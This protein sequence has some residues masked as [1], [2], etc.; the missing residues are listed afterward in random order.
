[1]TINKAS[2]AWV[3][4]GLIWGSNFIFMKW[5]TDYIT[6]LQVA[7]V[8][9]A[10]GL[11][12]VLIYAIAK[13]QIRLVHWRHAVHFLVMACLASAVYYYG[14]AKGTSLLPSGIAGAVSGA[15]PLFS[16]LAA[17]IF[18]PNETLS[19]LKIIG[20]FFGFIGVVI[21]AR[22]FET[23]LGSASTEGVLYMILGSLS[24][25]LSFVY[26]RKFITPLGISS[27]ALTSYQL[28]IAT[29]MMLMIT[30]LNGIGEISKSVTA[31][32][33]LILGLGFLGTG[34]AYIIYYYIVMQMGAIKA[35]TV[36]YMPPVVALFIGVIFV[37]EQIVLTDYIATVMILVG[38]ILVNKQKEI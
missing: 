11:F 9:I 5:A 10:L 23:G 26:A 38:V 18:L 36:T 19:R 14:F 37:K 22:P 28:G 17:G 34:I 20:L 35:S 7:C 32:S 29:V 12:P 27:A 30:E 2:I 1:M 21:I 6:P 24:I 3:A 15:I 16:L 25:G 33:G 13:Q 8:R 4:L 31:L